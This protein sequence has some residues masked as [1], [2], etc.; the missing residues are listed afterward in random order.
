MSTDEQ[1]STGDAER[2]GADRRKWIVDVQFEGGDATGIT[3]TED[4]SLG[5][6]YMST[7]ADLP[8]GT[9][10]F[11]K[12]TVAGENLEID[13]VVAYSAAGRG[14]GV[15]FV[16]PSEETLAVLRDKLGLE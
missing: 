13:G 14:V 11:M 9:R 6:L 8:T 1:E 12:L 15:K 5:G 10:I 2:R 3:H 4:L 7:E 16:Y